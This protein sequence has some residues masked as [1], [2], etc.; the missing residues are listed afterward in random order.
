MLSRGVVTRDDFHIL[1]DPL[2]HPPL[3]TQRVDYNERLSWSVQAGE[4]K[5]WH[6]G[7][8]GFGQFSSPASQRY[9]AMQRTGVPKPI[10][11]VA[12]YFT[13]VCCRWRSG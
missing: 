13:C 4:I 2:N 7:R 3:F 12:E 6:Q 8:L 5:P 10:L 1:P 9:R 11:D